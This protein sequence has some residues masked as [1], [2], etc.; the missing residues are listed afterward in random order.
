MGIGNCRGP[1]G[2]YG[3]QHLITPHGDWEPGNRS[4]SVGIDTVSLPLMGIGNFDGVAYEIHVD[5]LSLPLMGIG[6]PAHCSMSSQSM[7][8]I[9]PHGDWEHVFSPVKAL[10]AFASH[11][12]SW[13]LGTPPPG[14]G[15][16]SFM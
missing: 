13:G 14:S 3:Y 1:P 2:G 7:K 8:L 11:Y 10:I 16:S 15:G 12:P 5:T 6:N 4:S 9:T